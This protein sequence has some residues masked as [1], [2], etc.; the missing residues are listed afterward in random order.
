MDLAP[1]ILHLVGVPVPED[2]DGRV[3]QEIFSAGAG[4]VVRV[5]ADN[6]Q[7]ADAAGVNGDGYSCEEEAKVAERLTALGYL[8][9]ME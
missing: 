6:G 1:T 3:L 4:D 7:P 5:P 2:M 9:G 8:G